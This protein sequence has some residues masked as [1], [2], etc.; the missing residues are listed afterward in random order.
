MR[1]FKI[2]GT[3]TLAASLATSALAAEIELK[4]GHVGAPGSLFETSVNEFAKRVN[5]R[6]AGKVK[7]VTFGSSQLGKDSE[8]L[9]KLKR[10]YDPEDIF[11]HPQSVKA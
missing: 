9:Q 5:E 8:L 10:R 7:I 4:F 2:L 11:R 1:L 3:A 6:M